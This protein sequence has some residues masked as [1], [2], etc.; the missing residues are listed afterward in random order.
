LV[1]A[2]GTLAALV[3]CGRAELEVGAD[4]HCVPGAVLAC[5]CAGARPGA[6]VCAPDGASFLPCRC[7]PPTAAMLTPASGGASSAGAVTNGTFAGAG[8]GGSGAEG[9]SEPI[10]KPCPGGFTRCGAECVNVENNTRHCG[11]CDAA[12]DAGLACVLGGCQKACDPDTTLCGSEC[13]PLASDPENCGACGVTCGST[14][15]CLHGSCDCRTNWSRCGSVCVDAMTDDAHCGDCV[16]ACAAPAVCVGGT[17]RETSTGFPTFGFDVQHRGV[18]AGEQ[19]LPRHLT[20][21]RA[22]ADVELNPVV[23]ERGR[24]VVS[25]HT[26][27][28]DTGPVSVLAVDTGE[29]LWSYDF[30]PVADVGQPSVV[31][32]SIYVQHARGLD[33]PVNAMLYRLDAA[34]GDVLWSSLIYAQWEHYWAPAVGS[35]AVFVDGGTN[36]GLY[37]FAKD[38]G[39]QRFFSATLEAY[40]EWSPTL[41]DAGVLTMIAG[42]LRLHDQ[43]TGAVEWEESVDWAGSG[44]SMQTVVPER[45]GDVYLT[46]PPVLYAIRLSDQS[47]LWEDSGGYRSFPAVT[48]DTV[49][50]P[51]SAGL[52]ALDRKTGARVW[53][54]ALDD[55]ASYPPVVT[56]RCVFVSSDHVVYALDP[57]DGSELWKV[58]TAGW[59]SV[60][61]GY[62]FV[63]GADGTLSAFALT[64]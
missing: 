60:G 28:E 24:V 11:R 22:V 25:A 30:G 32:G 8:E 18:N 61:N 56:A 23:V 36:G 53:E 2:C 26:N 3:A 57:T 34:S 37:A 46:A 58:A 44:W 41:V 29:T 10:A 19:A 62:L 1:L 17:C 33:R 16:T 50:A 35:T 14:E 54:V 51:T 13:R 48:A 15:A 21:S 55:A 31:D 12:C 64:E 38:S 20:W 45:D 52:V 43:R 9:G 42:H 27:F 47:I 7:V 40:D 39:A 63:A 4:T 5:V 59:L 49:F 6:Q